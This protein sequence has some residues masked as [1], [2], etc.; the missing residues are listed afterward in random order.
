MLCFVS[1]LLKPDGKLITVR[2]NPS[3]GE[4]ST[5]ACT[6]PSEDL[7]AGKDYGF[8]VKGLEDYGTMCNLYTPDNFMREL[9]DN[10]GLD[11]GPTAEI[12]DFGRGARPGAAPFLLN[13]SSL[14]P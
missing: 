8:I 3:G 9:M 5:Y 6:T 10:A 7:K 4:F 1:T 13:V 2:P 11:F 14:K 12:K